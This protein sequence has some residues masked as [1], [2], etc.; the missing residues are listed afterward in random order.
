MAGWAD[1]VRSP[2][3]ERRIKREML[4]QRGEPPEAA[5]NYQLDHIIPV[6]LGGSP[7]DRSNLQLQPLAQAKRKDRVEK[8]AWRCV[9]AGTV[10]LDEARHDLAS[11][12]EGVYFKYPNLRCRW[13]PGIA[14]LP[15]LPTEPSQKPTQVAANEDSSIAAEQKF[16]LP[17]LN[18]D[19]EFSLPPPQDDPPHQANNFSCGQ[20]KYCKDMSCAEAC[21]HFVHC[22]ETDLDR[23]DDNIPCENVCHSP[24]KRN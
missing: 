3:L 16:S 17:P 13:K 24:C 9:C 22:H 20:R 6:C 10:P 8:L 4:K 2:S 14:D 21:F 12:W 11:D 15:S 19:G 18:E 1:S 5:D 23:D 7:T